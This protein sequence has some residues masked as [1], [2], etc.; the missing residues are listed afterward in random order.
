MEQQLKEIKDTGPGGNPDKSKSR[1]GLNWAA[2]RTRLPVDQ[3]V[4][5]VYKGV[6]CFDFCKTMMV[7]ITGG[8]RG[9]GKRE[10]WGKG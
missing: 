5:K 7:L 8:R 3:H 2:P 4:F 10:M 6:K 1:A 9:R